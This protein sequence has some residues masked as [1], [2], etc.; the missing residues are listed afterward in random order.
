MSASLTEKEVDIL[1]ADGRMN[2]L[3]V[4][5]AGPGPHPVVFFYMDAPGRR[6]ELSDMAR[7]IAAAGY[8]TVLPNLYYRTTRSFHMK[9]NDAGLREMLGLMGTLTNDLVVKDTQSMLR[10][11]DAEQAAKASRVGA[12]GYCMSGAFV[13]AAAACHTERFQCVASYHGTHLVTD[14][15]DSPHR[16]VKKVK[17]EMYFACAE[18]DE[19]ADEATIA[20]LTEA[21]NRCSARYR[22]E[23]YPGTQ[24]GFVFPRRANVYHEQAAQRHWERL[25]SLL[26]RCLS[27]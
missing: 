4:H 13:V 26:A 23:W 19:W 14:R 20:T 1:T 27:P 22:I 21:L 15:E 2:T 11:V 5:P 6:D 10:F 24:H 7:R 9:W 18:N 25:F 16:L 17:A 8:Y 3:V 12:V